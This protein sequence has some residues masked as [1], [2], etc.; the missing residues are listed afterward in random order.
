MPGTPAAPNMP[1]RWLCRSAKRWRRRRRCCENCP[2]GS[3]FVSDMKHVLPRWEENGGCPAEGRSSMASY[4]V[5]THSPPFLSP[6]TENSSL[7]VRDLG[8]TGDYDEAVPKL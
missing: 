7:S 1:F 3:E 4:L 2:S 6:V 5:T 8:L